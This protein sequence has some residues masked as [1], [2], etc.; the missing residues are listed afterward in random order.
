[1]RA[2]FPEERPWVSSKNRFSYSFSD[3][4][5][6]GPVRHLPGLEMTFLSRPEMPYPL[7]VRRLGCLEPSS[8]FWSTMA[9]CKGGDSVLRSVPF[10]EFQGTWGRQEVVSHSSCF[11]LVWL[12]LLTLGARGRPHPFCFLYYSAGL[13]KSKKLCQK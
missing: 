13:C 6:P 7:S 10:S 3:F 4:F 5:Q 9:W 12:I 1:M 8:C 11:D 2:N